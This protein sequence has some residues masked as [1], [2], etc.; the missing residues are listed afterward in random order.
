MSDCELEEHGYEFSG[1]GAQHQNGVSER[2]IGTITRWSRCMILHS[3]L[4]W[5]SQTAYSLWPFTMTYTTWLFNKLP[6]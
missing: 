4:H 1:V 2:A 3:A 5:P 6:Y